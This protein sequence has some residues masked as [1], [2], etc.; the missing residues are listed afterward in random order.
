MENAIGHL[1]ELTKMAEKLGCV[2]GKMPFL[3]AKY[4][5][6]LSYLEQLGEYCRLKND[7]SSTD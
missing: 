2:E 6:M 5:L 1:D 4:S 3:D 7:T